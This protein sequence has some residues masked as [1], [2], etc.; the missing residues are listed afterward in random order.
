M[1]STMNPLFTI[2]KILAFHYI[3]QE[4]FFLPKIL[5]TIVYDKDYILCYFNES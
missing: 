2:I 5:F 4:Y 3:L 1:I